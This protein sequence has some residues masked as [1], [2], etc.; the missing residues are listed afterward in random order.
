MYV[1]VTIAARIERAEARMMRD[2]LASLVGSQRAPAAFVREL[3][4]GTATYVRPG[5]PMNKIIGAGLGEPI[6][7][8]AL[9]DLERCLAHH[10]EPVRVELSTLADPRTY[11]QL[12]ARDYRVIGFENVLACR[13]ATPT[14]HSAAAIEV[15]PV[16]ERLLAQ[17]R[18]TTVEAAACPDDTGVPVD[19]FTR[20]VIGVAVDDSI[21]AP[22]ARRYLAYRDGAVAGAACM[23]IEGDVAVFTG[24]ATLPPHR[25]HGVQAALLA[26]RLA[27]ARAAGAALAII[28]T[29]PGTQ[30][31]ANVMKQGFALVYARAVLVRAA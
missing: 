14:P 11:A 21:Q 29:A 16:T 12:A 28:T 13:L 25:R 1:D 19:T 23:S 17:F 22:A 4:A 18:E 24:S 2:L 8:A 27:D 20:D 9:G 10:R 26:R 31:Q 6:D 15:Q 30:S 7:E 5:S 3:G